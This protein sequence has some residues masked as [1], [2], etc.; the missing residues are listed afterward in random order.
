[1]TS[2]L[3]RTPLDLFTFLLEMILLTLVFICSLLA[4]AS[5]LASQL[6][7]GAQE[8]KLWLDPRPGRI[9]ATWSVVATPFKKGLTPG[10]HTSLETFLLLFSVPVL[11]RD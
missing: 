11:C 6:L 7:S 5:C 4:V 9:A 3:W 10:P 2:H 8:A 1:M